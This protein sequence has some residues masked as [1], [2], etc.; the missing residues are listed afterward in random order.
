MG[1]T[2]SAPRRRFGR[3]RRPEADITQVVVAHTFGIPVADLSTH[4]RGDDYTCFARHVAMYLT[5]VTYGLTI[6]EVAEAFGRE[7]SS[8]SYAC[9]RIEDLRDDPRV[10]RRLTQLENLIRAVGQIGFAP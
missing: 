6:G 9:H 7:R 1:Q 5:H 4:R 8:A 2:I 10:D 3:R